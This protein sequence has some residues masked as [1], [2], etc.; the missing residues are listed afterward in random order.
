MVT[1]YWSII[2]ADNRPEGLV[3]WQQYEGR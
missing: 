3:V 2:P 1:A